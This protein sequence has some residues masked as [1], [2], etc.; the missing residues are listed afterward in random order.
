MED[1]RQA[2]VTLPDG[3]P[4]FFV[5]GQGYRGKVMLPD[6]EFIHDVGVY[7]GYLDPQEQPAQ[8]ELKHLFGGIEFGARPTG[9]RDDSYLAEL[10][11]GIWVK[12][13]IGDPHGRAPRR[14][15]Q[16][17]RPAAQPAPRQDADRRA[18]H[19]RD[20]AAVLLRERRP[21]R[22]ERVPDVRLH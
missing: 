16:E 13:I 3:R 10:G 11:D 8:L 18:L 17:L 4:G 1:V 14:V 5:T 15:L 6:G 19:E 21:R 20:Q 22:P 7:G 9:T 2:A 12:G